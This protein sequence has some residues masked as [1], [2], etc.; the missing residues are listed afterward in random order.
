MPKSLRFMWKVSLGL[1][2]AG[3]LLNVAAHD[4]IGCYMCFT[5]FAVSLLALAL[6]PGDEEKK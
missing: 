3:L 6:L 2:S 1:N 4:Q 5:G